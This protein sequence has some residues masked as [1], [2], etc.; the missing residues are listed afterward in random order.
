MADHRHSSEYNSGRER[1]GPKERRRDHRRRTSIR[2]GSPIAR[3]SPRWR[4]IPQHPFKCVKGFKKHLDAEEC[5]GGVRKWLVPSCRFSSPCCV[6]SCR[7][8]GGGGGKGG[9]FSRHPHHLRRCCATTEGGRFMSS[10]DGAGMGPSISVFRRF[11]SRL[12]PDVR[13][14]SSSRPRFMPPPAPFMRG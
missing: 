11:M 2:R 4:A 13:S 9:C 14:S 8:G 7:T 3:R 12:P 1:E 5:E 10:N 6:A